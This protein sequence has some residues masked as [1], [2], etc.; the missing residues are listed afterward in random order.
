MLRPFKLTIPIRPELSEEAESLW[1]DQGNVRQ[2][3][4][5][6]SGAEASALAD[7]A[8]EETTETSEVEELMRGIQRGI[9]RG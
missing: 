6:Q 3:I 1:S 8:D 7:E 9:L 4:T 2:P 5:L